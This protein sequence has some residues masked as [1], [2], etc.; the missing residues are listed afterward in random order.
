MSEIKKQ[1]S[2]IALV[3][4]SFSILLSFMYSKEDEWFPLIRKGDAW[5]SDIDS[6]IEVHFELERS[7]VGKF[8]YNMKLKT[9]FKSQVRIQASLL[10]EEEL[11]HLIPCIIHGDNNKDMVK[12][13]QFPLLTYDDEQVVSCS[14]RWEFRADRASHPV[15]MLCCKRGAVGISVEPYSES[16]EAG[17]NELIRNGVY[18]EL[19]NNFG[20]TLGY[21][22]FPVTYINK[23]DFETGEFGYAEST[24][25]TVFNSSVKGS[26][27]GYSGEG[28]LG[29]HKIIR[30]SYEHYRELAQYKKSYKE[31][32]TG[33]IDSLITIN[34][35]EKE[36]NYTNMACQVPENNELKAWRGLVE[37][38]WT[39]GGVLAYPLILA[40][41]ILSLGE[42]R[43]VGRKSGEDILNEVVDAYNEQSGLLNDVVRPWHDNWPDS[44]VNGW[45]TGFGLTKDSHCAYTNGSALYYIFKVID[46][47]KQHKLEIQHRWLEVG[48][49]VMN[50]VI[51]LQREDGAFGYQFSINEK[52][53]IDWEGFAGCWFAAAA[54]LAYKLTQDSKYLDSSKKGIAFYSTFVKELNC[55]GTP[56]DTWK[57]IDQEGNLAFIKCARY[58]HELTG[59]DTYLELLT[60]G[61]EYEY[62]WR[63]G[64]KARPEFEPLKGCNWN[65]CGGSVTS[66]SNPH[67]HPMGLLVTA[68]LKYLAKQTGDEYHQNRAED[69]LAW[70]MAS[71][72]L[73]PDV[74]GYGQYGVLSERFCPSDGLV[75]EKYSDGTPCST[76][77]S[78]N[79]WAAANAL[80]A[81]CEELL[82]KNSVS[83]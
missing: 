7:A 9:S 40:E 26:I 75:I 43:F 56:M 20:V 71:M 62:L 2:S 74:M 49:S 70:I 15:S 24:K 34:W 38:G 39:G 45:W 77:F 47:R 48:L 79:G 12:L 4:E 23:I 3:V 63:Y 52:K 32:A 81:I 78:Y 59:E 51:D 16:N 17:E 44:H 41:K 5:V 31:A 11:F 83:L 6:G 60:V 50:T 28:R 29:A 30:D 68:D 61:A 1:E 69:G 42:D 22:N 36:N 72:E 66:I 21:T 53:V 76:W 73:Y 8:N 33:L 35:S 37:I 25:D 57:S 65:S 64:F 54:A 46:F 27:Y 19:P 58:L 80:E 13:D 14:P 55:W 18:C 67:I 10:D 82:D